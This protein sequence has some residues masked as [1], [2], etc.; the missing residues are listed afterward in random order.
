MLNGRRL[1]PEEIQ[2]VK[3][4]LLFEADQKARALAKERRE[5]RIRDEARRQAAEIRE[6][7]RRFLARQDSPK[8]GASMKEA[9]LDAT[10]EGLRVQ[11]PG[12]RFL[13]VK[14]AAGM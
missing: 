2:A 7:A 8:V 13:S 9:L 3:A 14:R 5:A 10:R 12:G 4:R 11:G 1:T 6:E